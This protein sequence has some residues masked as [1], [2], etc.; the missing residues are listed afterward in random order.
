MPTNSKQF[1]RA[2]AE[3]KADEACSCGKCGKM[4]SASCQTFCACPVSVLSVSRH[5][6]AQG[7]QLQ[8]TAVQNQAEGT[9]KAEP[10]KVLVCN[11]LKEW[12]RSSP[13]FQLEATSWHTSRSVSKDNHHT[14]NRCGSKRHW[15]ATHTSCLIARNGLH[16][17]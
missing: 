17:D 11:R 8:P 1:S 14:G 13:C 9:V 3:D 4:G 7:T 6:S 15:D 10:T 5:S 12:S 2:S 16:V